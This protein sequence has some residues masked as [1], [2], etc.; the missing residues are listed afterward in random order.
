MKSPFS[1]STSYVLDKSHFSE[2]YDESVPIDNSGRRYQKS[3]VLSLVG[4]ALLYTPEI[5][6]YFA[7]FFIGLGIVDGLSVRFQKPWWLARQML[8][9]AANS[10]LTLRIDEEGVKSHSFY[11]DSAML[12]TDVTNIEQTQRGWL[13]TVNSGKTYMSNRCL[14][15]EAISYLADKMRQINK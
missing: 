5:S 12:W 2:T 8:S 14:S 6:A 1:Y 10:E 7:W 15:E 13:L 3:V 4:L 11:V 9:R